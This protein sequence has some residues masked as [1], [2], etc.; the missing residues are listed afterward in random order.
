VLQPEGTQDKGVVGGGGSDPDVDKAEGAYDAG[1]LGEMAV[2]IPEESG[3]PELP[4]G[5]Q[6]GSHQKDP[7]KPT[8]PEKGAGRENSGRHG[9]RGNVGNSSKPASAHVA[10]A[11]ACTRFS[12]HRGEGGERYNP[13]ILAYAH[14]AS[15]R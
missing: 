11:G 10:Q 5:E 14:F 7:Q 1:V 6:E 2:V 12:C 3:M 13:L 8:A 9:G 4:V 15:L